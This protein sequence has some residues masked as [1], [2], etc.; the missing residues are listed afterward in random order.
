MKASKLYLLFAI[1]IPFLL[2]SVGVSSW[3]TG[4]ETKTDNTLNIDKVTGKIDNYIINGSTEA[5][6][7]YASFTTLEG[8]VKSAN[9]LAKKSTKVNMYLTTGSYITVSNKAITLESGVSLF[10]PYD[11]KTYDIS[12]DSDIKNLTDGFIDISDANIKKYNVSKLTFINSTL[13]ISSGAQVYIGGKFRQTGVSGEYSEIDLDKS[14]NITVSGSLYCHGYVKEI[15]AINVDQDEKYNDNLFDNSFDSSRYILVENGGY[16]SAPQAFYDAG[17]MGELTELNSKG[18]FPINVFDFP[19]VQTYLRIMSGATFVAPARLSRSTGGQTFNVRQTLN[20]VSSSSSDKP[21]LTL[22][23]G[24]ISFEYCPLKPG[25]TKKDAS[26]TYIVINGLT[27]AGYLEIKVNG[28]TISTKSTFLPFS[29]KLKLIIGS[30]G[31]FKTGLYKIKF[32]GGS[33]LKVLENGLLDI[34]SEIIGY[35]ANSAQGVIDYPTD[36]GDSK[37]VINGSI[38][39]ESAAKIGGHFSTECTGDEASIDLSSIAQSQLTSTAVEGLSG[40]SIKIYATGDFFDSDT[41]TIASNLLRAGLMIKSDSSGK[42][43]W[44][45]GGNLISYILTITVDNSNN[46]EHPLI[47]YKVYKYDASGNKTLL[48]TEGVYM[49]SG[50]EY[51]FEKGESF[52][53]E[54][55]DRAEKTEF[56]KQEGSN[57]SFVSGSKYAIKGDTEITITPGEGVLVRFSIDSESGSAGSTVKIYESLTKG[58]TYYQIGQSSA[59]TAVEIPVRK[60]AYV[61][62]EV[63][64]GPCR[65]KLEEHYIFDGIVTIKTGDDTTKSNGRKLS[66]KFEKNYGFSLFGGAKSTSTD[67]LISGDS[68]IHAYIKN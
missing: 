40:T 34:G 30:Q 39:L 66:T 57:Y 54:S 47:G 13:T 51:P 48:S 29:Y 36:Y 14:S 61:K 67:T 7:P 12:S 60:N 25:Y 24:F 16:F 23:D 22:S 27:D 32:M 63:I 4:F 3:V 21:L 5:D 44:A 62:Y 15:D 46:Y 9:E 52:E 8:A 6:T 65:N 19:N 58:G 28:V 1:L 10:M 20:I 38:K 17:S 68:T 43:C 50:G 53:V 35:K 31:T 11:G 41:N 2:I 64:Q 37:F 42:K 56:T 45:D 55:L 33:M 18:V 59:G 26:A 49:T